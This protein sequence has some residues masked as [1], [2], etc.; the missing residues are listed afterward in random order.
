MNINTDK[1]FENF[2]VGTSNKFAFHAAKTVANL[3]EKTDYHCN[4]LF[5][6]GDTSI[7][8]THLINAICNE[9]TSNF[10]NIKITYVTAEEFINEFI[11][12]LGNRNLD[13]FN[14]KYKSNTDLLII[15]DI[16]F[17]LDK[18]ATQEEF[19]HVINTLMSNKKQVV[20]TSDR[21]PKNISDVF[22]KLFSRL[23]YGVIVEIAQPDYET[24]NEIIK[25]IAEKQNFEISEEISHYIAENI[26]TNVFIIEGIVNSINAICLCKSQLPTIEMAQEI[27]SKILD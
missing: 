17:M 7:G 9:A 14:K 19:F 23:T 4:P 16:Q 3:S 10:P 24:K 13:D 20:I 1:T 26:K 11:F 21:A 2:V 18:L 6:Y 8:K 5:I 27:M 22:D 12:A 25:A 15:E